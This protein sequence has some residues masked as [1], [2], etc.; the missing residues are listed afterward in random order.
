MAV[1]VLAA[2][3]ERANMRN[4][5]V[6]TLTM[7]LF[8]ATTML[9]AVSVLS[10]MDEPSEDICL[11]NLASGRLGPLLFGPTLWS[12]YPSF[13]DPM[14]LA[15][16]YVLFLVGGLVA[17]AVYVS[18]FKFQRTLGATSL[19]VLALG[20]IP[21]VQGLFVLRSSEVEPAECGSWVA[22]MILGVLYASLAAAVLAI[23]DVTGGHKTVI[24]LL[25]RA[26]VR[27]S[28]LAKPKHLGGHA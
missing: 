23:V 21:Y 6:A 8:I 18:R 11:E 14:A 9:T 27:R 5:S 13:P 25:N 24:T 26:R 3:L 17:V 4:S 19:V 22:V 28:G 15:N 12:Q 1:H 20:A 2:E 16:D 7:A 10:R